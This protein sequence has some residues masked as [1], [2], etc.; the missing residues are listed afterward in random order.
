MQIILKWSNSL[1]KSALGYVKLQ[2]GCFH[3]LIHSNL[4]QFIS[5]WIPIINNTLCLDFSFHPTHVSP[6]LPGLLP[7]FLHC[8]AP[9]G[10]CEP[11]TSHSYYFYD[12][13]WNRSEKSSHILFESQTDL[14]L[15]ADI[16]K[17]PLLA[18]IANSLFYHSNLT[19]GKHFFCLHLKVNLV[20]TCVFCSPLFMCRD[21]PGALMHSHESALS[22]PEYELLEGRWYQ[23]LPSM[24]SGQHSF[25]LVWSQGP[26]EVILVVLSK[27]W[28]HS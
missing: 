21:S 7:F 1:S 16:F 17:G 11:G 27:E 14:W 18:I 9:T 19:S 13:S 5:Y 20:F 3:T 25:G 6:R 4:I 22:L 8:A 15:V 2:K 24:L 26:Y 23:D 12:L 28:W 10:H